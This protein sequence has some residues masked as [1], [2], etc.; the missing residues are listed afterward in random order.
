MHRFPLL[1][2]DLVVG[3]VQLDRWSAVSD[4]L[5]ETALDG[6]WLAPI[7]DV[8]KRDDATVEERL[9]SFSVVVGGVQ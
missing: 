7:V 1:L 5:N 4:A 9:H 3:T 6:F 2:G 8:I